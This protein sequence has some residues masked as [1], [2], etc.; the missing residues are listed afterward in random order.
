MKSNSP[1]SKIKKN[2]IKTSTP[3]N[4]YTDTITITRS[5]NNIKPNPLPSKIKKNTIKTFNNK[6]LL[7][8]G[9][10]GLAIGAL[11]ENRRQYMVNELDRMDR[12]SK[13]KIRLY[14]ELI[15]M[16]KNSN[17]SI[18]SIED[19]LD[20]IKD[21]KIKEE[22]LL[23][24]FRNLYTVNDSYEKIIKDLNLQIKEIDNQLKKYTPKTTNTNIKNDTHDIHDTNYNTLLNENKELHKQLNNC[25]NK[26]QLKT[27]EINRHFTN[28]DKLMKSKDNDK[29]LIDSIINQFNQKYKTVI[30]RDLLE[31]YIDELFTELRLYEVMNKSLRETIREK[32]LLNLTLTQKI[33]DLSG[34]SNDKKEIERLSFQIFQ[35]DNEILLLK[36][37]NHEL[38]KNLNN[39]VKYSKNQAFEIDTLKNKFNKLK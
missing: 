38:N 32:E 16:L 28:T 12:S 17:I 23:Q 39:C 8:A 21:S 4:T 14:D 20:F 22:K 3:N 2:T 9:I 35:L 1:P 7:A 24:E 6:K 10:G 26:L 31:N 29:L 25:K 5:K 27:N 13:D 15:S 30:N 11:L 33:K 37:K 18:V 34:N 36:N 19:L